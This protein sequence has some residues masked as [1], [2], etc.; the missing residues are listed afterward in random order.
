MQMLERLVD[1]WGATV[2]GKRYVRHAR[3]CYARTAYVQCVSPGCKL[4]CAAGTQEASPGCKLPCAAGT[5]EAGTRSP[6]SPRT[7]TQVGA[8]EVAVGL[9]RCVQRRGRACACGER[10]QREAH[11]R[12]LALNAR[13]SARIQRPITRPMQL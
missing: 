11:V 8:Y 7:H 4:P 1:A 9:S 13:S 2:R 3:G 10:R 5:Q 12:V 6:R